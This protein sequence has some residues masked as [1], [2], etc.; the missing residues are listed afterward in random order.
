[1]RLN[2]DFKKITYEDLDSAYHQIR[3]EWIK[4]TMDKLTLQ[5]QKSESQY[6]QTALRFCWHDIV[7]VFKSSEN[8]VFTQNNTEEWMK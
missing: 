7:N 5:I 1:M 6:Q 4:R 2:I 8:L 3:R